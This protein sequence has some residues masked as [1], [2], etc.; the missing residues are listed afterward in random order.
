MDAGSLFRWQVQMNNI[1]TMKTN[2]ALT[3]SLLREL[4]IPIS[5]S[6]RLPTDN[7]SV[8]C[9]M[10]S[11]FWATMRLRSANAAGR[12]RHRTEIASLSAGCI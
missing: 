4:V 8:S 11:D 3:I 2:A 5:A 9:R 10:E 12:F 6:S 7:M 1:A